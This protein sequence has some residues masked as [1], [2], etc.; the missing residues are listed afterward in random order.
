M[1][2]IGEVVVVVAG[3]A[4]ATADAIHVDDILGNTCWSATEENEVGEYGVSVLFIVSNVANGV[5][6]CDCLVKLFE[7]LEVRLDCV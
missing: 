5:A 7:E 6:T 2:L 3:A 1:V 4:A